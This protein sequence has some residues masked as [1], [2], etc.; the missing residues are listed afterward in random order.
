MPSRGIKKLVLAM[1]VA[2]LTLP[3]FA[4]ADP[5]ERERALEQRVADLERM[6]QQLLSE[7]EQKRPDPAPQIQQDVEELRAEVAR[8]DTEKA[9]QVIRPGT[10]FSFGGFVKHDMMYSRYS[11]GSVAPQSILRDFYV[12]GAVPV[13]GESSTTDFDTHARETRFFFNV[14]RPEDGLQG[15][16]ELDFTSRT[17]GDERLTNATS[18]SIRHM[19]VRWNNLLAGQHWSTFQNVGALPENLDFVGPAE[20]TIFVRQAQI[21]YTNGPWQ[22]SLENPETTVTPFGGG[23][24]IITD[25]ANVPDVVLR[26]NHSAEWGSFVA[27]F[28]ARQLGIDG[29]GGTSRETSFAFSLSGKFDIGRNDVRWMFSGGPGIGRYLGL[30]TA[31]DAVLDANGDLEA[32][33][34]YGAFVSYRHFWSD[35]W[36]SNL[37]LSAFKA[38]HET[39]LTGFG[40]TDEAESVHVNL[41]Y[42]A[43]SRLRFGAEYIYG[44]REVASG[45]DGNMNRVQ[46]STIY[47]F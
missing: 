2:G 33:D 45:A 46:F 20:S 18:P 7:R 15:Y 24:R 26:Y 39:N 13:G 44:R 27:A 32:I 38:D 14:E 16:I 29:P 9:S 25:T 22:F 1:C 34:A 4:D 11:G 10:N 40:V 23:G 36:R 6:V 47:A 17:G 28:L 5:S 12:A 31:N 19:F 35:Q 21:R 41:I 42:Q 37:T 8:L 3:A 43:N 30:N